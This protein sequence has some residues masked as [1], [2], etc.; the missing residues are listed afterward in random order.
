MPFLPAHDGAPDDDMDGRLI[1]LFCFAF[2]GALK[3]AEGTGLDGR[4]PLQ[5]HVHGALAALISEVDSAM[6]CGEETAERLQDINWVAPLACRHAQIIS[7]AMRLSPV[8][9]ARFG[10]LFSSR[11]KLDR[12]IS[13]HEDTILTFLEHTR[14]QNEWGVKVFFDRSKMLDSMTAAALK[15]QEADLPKSPGARYLHEQRIRH[16]LEKRVDARAR[17]MRIAIAD[18]LE[19]HA[20]ES[21]ERKITRGEGAEEGRTL[22][23]NLAY[24]VPGASL[25]A[26]HEEETRLN[27]EYA[28][29][30][31]VLE[32]TGPWP[33]YS[34]TPPIGDEAVRENADRE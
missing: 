14:G 20:S 12:F 17:T 8:F 32:T 18:A 10:S 19:I 33:P 15:E 4:S 34:F 9:P 24:L 21:G 31:I 5:T 22:I 7:D 2:S 23:A 30:G 3:S 28:T 16:G 25:E 29:E 1:C 11:E 6:F 13:I 26:F 27:A